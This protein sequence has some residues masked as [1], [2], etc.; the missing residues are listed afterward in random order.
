MVGR[1][2]WLEELILRQTLRLWF[3]QQHVFAYT[4]TIRGLFQAL[5]RE[6]LTR[7]GS[8]MTHSSQ[9]CLGVPQIL[10]IVWM[11]NLSYNNVTQ[12]ICILYNAAI[13]ICVLCNL[14]II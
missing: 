1:S 13:F 5:P 4:A 8:P 7:L 6:L 14:F 3:W 12:I 9:G 11:I 10:I 2:E